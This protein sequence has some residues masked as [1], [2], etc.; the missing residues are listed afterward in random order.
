M[1]LTSLSQVI[2][3]QH[4]PLEVECFKWHHGRMGF[5]ADQTDTEHSKAAGH[6][7]AERILCIKQ[8]TPCRPIFILAHSAGCAVTL[9]CTES[10]PPC[11]LARIIL[12]APSVS[13]CY[14]LRPA[15][16]CARCG[17][18][19]FSSDKDCWYLGFGIWLLGTADGKRTDAAGRIGFALPA[20]CP[21]D[22]AL[23][24]KLRS[25]PWDPSLS[26]TGNHGGHYGT[27]KLGFMRSQVV[28]LLC[29]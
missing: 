11:T 22:A 14:D 6:C 23:Y 19:V 13:A 24:A 15:L 9:A 8:Q 21:E 20:A 16:I 17:I 2:D 18:D 7:L 29:P 26:C 4:L 28:P 27:F 3:E 5:V 10:L 25:H 1:P 12:V